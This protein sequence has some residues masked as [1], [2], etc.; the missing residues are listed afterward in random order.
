M[1]NPCSGL[2]QL[3]S[4]TGQPILLTS[5]AFRLTGPPISLAVPANST[6]CLVYFPSGLRPVN[7]VSALA[8]TLPR[9]LTNSQRS[10]MNSLTCPA[11]CLTG[12]PANSLTVPAGTLT[13]PA[14]YLTGGQANTLTG[15]VNSLT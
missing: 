5:L 1:L 4:L 11:S 14:I 3:F 10:K 8:N 2:P 6:A 15:L 7:S 13:G 9:G 12:D